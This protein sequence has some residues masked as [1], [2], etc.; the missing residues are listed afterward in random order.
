MELTINGKTARIE[1]V[2]T[3]AELIAARGLKQGLVAVEQNGEIVPRQ[4]FAHR[5]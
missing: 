3:V 4:E 5:S 2:S 1:G